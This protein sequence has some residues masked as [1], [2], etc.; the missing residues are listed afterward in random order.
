MSKGVVCLL[1]VFSVFVSG[2][3]PAQTLLPDAGQESGMERGIWVT[4]FSEEKV[5]Y[6]HEAVIRLIDFCREEGIGEIYL[7]LYRAGKAYYRSD[8]ADCTTY[9]EMTE[10][11]GVD[12]LSL[13]MEEA[14][15]NNIQVF[16]WVNVFSLAE[17]EQADIVSRFGESVYTRDQHGR[18]SM[19]GKET[20]ITD[21]Y[22]LRDT[23]LFLE[24]GDLRVREYIAQIVAEITETLPGLSG[25][26]LDY[27]R[28]PHIV[29]YLPDARFN[30]FGLVYGYGTQNVKRFKEATG[31]DPVDKHAVRENYQT[32]EDWKREQV[33][34]CVGEVRR[35]MQERGPEMLLSCAVMPSPER[36]YAV[37]FQDWPLWLDRHIVDYV[38]IMDYTKDPRLFSINAA[39]S[40]ALQEKTH[41][42]IGIGA[43]LAK[44]GVDVLH[45]QYEAAAWLKPGGV[46]FFSYD[47]LIRL[48]RLPR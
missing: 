25:I 36:A 11:A 22:Y 33:T 39:S 44:D 12:T 35:V 28:Y 15:K 4:C 38:V 29:P 6:S 30:D 3:A 10:A 19:R 2:A 18:V 40:L 7:Q 43:F 8:I 47:D 13:L 46:V 41:I 14:A 26:H 45:R 42:Y 21:T 48:K 9:R 17:N 31:I 16:A 20:D 27:V 23:Q 24:P 37:A 5:L 32:W 34:A 1:L